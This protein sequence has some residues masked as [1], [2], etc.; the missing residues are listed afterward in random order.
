LNHQIQNKD[1]EPFMKKEIFDLLAKL[2]PELVAGSSI[3]KPVPAA[4]ISGELAFCLDALM[5]TVGEQM[6]LSPGSV[7]E[8]ILTTGIENWVS[9][10]PDTTKRFIG[11][12]PKI[13]RNAT[14]PVDDGMDD[15]DP[16]PAHAQQAA[17]A[18]M[19]ES[20]G[21]TPLTAHAM[22]KNGASNGRGDQRGGSRKNGKS[23]KVRPAGKS[24]H[25]SRKNN[26][27]RRRY[28]Q[29]KPQAQA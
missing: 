26:S 29:N 15:D 20:Y 2:S 8:K 13:R 18:Q 5:N 1:Y 14:L 19:T 17:Y 10:L 23:K 27:R 3:P 12:S 24:Q 22:T 28:S 21:Y 6:N 4:E 25:P 16:D 9:Q 11:L 7:L